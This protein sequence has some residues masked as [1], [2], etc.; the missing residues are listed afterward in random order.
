[1]K[2][3]TVSELDMNM[4]QRVNVGDSITRSAEL[5]PDHPAIIDG[6]RQVTYAE[7]DARSNRL[8]SALLA[9]GLRKGDVVGVLTRNS[10]ELL[11]TYFACAKAGLVCSPANLALTPNEIGYCLNDSRA[12]VLVVE[13]ALAELYRALPDLP[14][15]GHVYWTGPTA[16]IA[17]NALLDELIAAGD[18]APLEVVVQDRDPV[19]VL[20]TSGTT[21]MPKGVVTSHLAVS[22]AALS[23]ALANEF[24]AGTTV[25]GNLP[26]FH[27][28][29]I[30]CVS[31]PA[32]I[33]GG[34]I[35]L[36]NGFDAKD[37][38]RL[39]EQHRINMFVM[40]PMMYGELLDEP[41]VWKRDL[42]SVQRAL[43]AMAP[44]P[45]D[46]LKAVHDLLP[47]ADVV[48]GSGQTEFTPA[49]CVQRPEHQWSK[50]GSWGS[51]TAMTRIAIMG[52]NGHLQPRGELGEIVYR[53]PQVMTEYLNQPE[54]TAESFAH[55]WF[56][57]GDMAWMDDEGVVWFTDR[58]KDVI[59]TGGE[60]VASIEVERCLLEH[61]DVI[62]AATV[63][64]PHDR[65]GEAV[66]GVVV[67]R[68][69]ARV[70]EAALLEHCRE[71]LAGFKVPKAIRFQDALPRTGTGKIQKHL[72]RDELKGYYTEGS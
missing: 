29:A 69:G 42:S 5:F 56:H 30:N 36:I 2:G 72:M 10:P 43:Y 71:H 31:L 15:L 59:K 18:P 44:M 47:N 6:D 11:L 45:S 35:V 57:S 19:Q 27:T 60:N 4:V 28:T 16:D 54:K 33:V 63:G 12:K 14:E 67:L 13:D 66:T 20:Y 17:G 23:N 46:R 7:L 55:G 51:A 22:F 70:D 8:G 26:L 1:M 38:G 41:E 48:L 25:L 49:T 64:L 21:A 3:H 52:E 58:K 24:K 53:G 68:D 40:L 39:I 65:W 32:L 37:V 62:E 61:P 9:L 50:A 34:A